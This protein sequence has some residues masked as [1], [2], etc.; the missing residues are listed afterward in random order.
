MWYPVIAKDVLLNPGD[1]SPGPATGRYA[2]NGI[3][4]ATRLGDFMICEVDADP[5]VLQQMSA[6]TD[7]RL[8][9]PTLIPLLLDDPAVDIARLDEI[10]EW[11]GVDLRPIRSVFPVG[12]LGTVHD[13]LT[14]LKGRASKSVLTRFVA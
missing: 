8:I 10:R 4:G 6:D 14:L 1:L 5:A 12:T 13:V 3:S 11:L 2:L 7:L 9:D